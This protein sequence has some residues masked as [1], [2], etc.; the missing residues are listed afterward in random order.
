MYYDENTIEINSQTD[1]KL[2]LQSIK[3]FKG[4]SEDYLTKVST[5]GESVMKIIST[6][7]F[8]LESRNINQIKIDIDYGTHRGIVIKLNV[9]NSITINTESYIGEY[10]MEL[11]EKKIAQLYLLFYLE[12]F[13]N[14]IQSY[15]NEK[16]S[17]LW[18]RDKNI[19]FLK[20]VAEALTES[21]EIK[22][23][24]LKNK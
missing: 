5:S 8:L 20:D 9:N 1:V 24:T 2:V 6:L 10:I 4:D 12:L 18:N 3:G 16:E 21:I 7:S 14:I 13:P 17:E 22:L 23:S 11:Q 19:K 15:Q